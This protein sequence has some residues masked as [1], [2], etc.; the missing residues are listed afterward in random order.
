[1][2][3]YMNIFLS[4]SVRIYGTR[5]MAA[6]PPLYTISFHR[7]DAALST[8]M[9]PKP[10]STATDIFVL[11]FICNFHNKAIGNSPKVQS[12]TAETALCA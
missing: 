5:M 6:A 4:P 11:E 3:L 2:I 7:R 10:R 12:A 1:M 9:I 8:Y